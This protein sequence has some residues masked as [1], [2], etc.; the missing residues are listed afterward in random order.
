[1]FSYI[2]VVVFSLVSLLLRGLGV[3]PAL[4]MHELFHLFC[5]SQRARQARAFY[6]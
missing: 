5:N 3:L 1:M 2:L 4:P 6:A